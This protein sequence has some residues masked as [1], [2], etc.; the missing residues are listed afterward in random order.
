MK[1]NG[2][3][4]AS[5]SILT[6]T[7]LV[8]VFWLVFVRA[9]SPPEVF[10]HKIDLVIAE[11]GTEQAE[12]AD[13]LIGKLQ[14]KCVERAADKIKLRGKLEYAKYARCVVAATSLANAERC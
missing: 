9:P 13:A 1:I 2:S 4:I 8:F 3:R 11:V 14:S 6:I 5:I 10:Q 12:G 7:A